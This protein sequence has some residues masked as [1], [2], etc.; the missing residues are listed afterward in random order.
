MPLPN[1]QPGACLSKNSGDVCGGCVDAIF[2]K[3]QSAVR[4]P[5]SKQ[6]H[7]SASQL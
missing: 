4:L 1:R 3:I 6:Q 5:A 2:S 7:A